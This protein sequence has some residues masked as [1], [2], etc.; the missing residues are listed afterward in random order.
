MQESVARWYT[1]GEPLSALT[2]DLAATFDER[3]A[4][5]IAMTET[6][7]SAAQGTLRGYEASGVVKALIWMTANDERVCPYCGALDG[8]TVALDGKFSDRLPQDLQDKLKGKTFAHPP[9]HP[10]CRCRLGAQVV[11]VGQ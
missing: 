1:N 7:H 8:E 10:G 4:K 5:L 6:T 2:R 11:E 3:R 9:A